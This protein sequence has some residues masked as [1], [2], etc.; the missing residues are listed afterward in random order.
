MVLAAKSLIDREPNPTEE[1][2]REVLSGVLCR[3]TGYIK[4]VQAVLR[5]AAVMR[6]E[7]PPPIG[8]EILPT[9]VDWLPD[10]NTDPGDDLFSHSGG[11]VAT[12]TR[13]MPDKVKTLRD[14]KGWTKVG[15]PEPKVDAIKLVQGKPAFA[16][17]IEM[18]GMLTAKI[19]H[20]PVAHALIKRID[21]S[22]AR[23][24]EGVAAVLTHEDIPRVIY[25]TAGQSDP[26]P[27]PLDTFSLDRK[28]RFVGDRVAF[29]AAETEEI[30]RKA[31]ELI[32][33]EYEELPA[34]LDT[35][36]SMKPGAPII[37]DEP[38][39]VQFAESNPVQK[40]CR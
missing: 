3:C 32:E 21:A 8:E 26:I 40:H 37:H 20:S 38:E 13:V 17:D 33:V 29:V 7:T 31:L 1:Q 14:E 22:K 10:D 25:S 34:I 15:H 16:D 35:R 30:A 12:K 28:V 27:G 11:G 2:V 9:K 19:L 36:D 4:P 18:R 39:Y 24:L 23:A 5:A 6:G